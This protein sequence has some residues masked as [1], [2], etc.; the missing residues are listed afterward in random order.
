MLT[1]TT[2][3]DG[4]VEVVR[5][6]GGDINV[7]RTK[8]EMIPATEP[9]R[10]VDALTA[11]V[12]ARVVLTST[13]ERRLFLAEH[14][15]A[16]GWTVADLA[17]QP[18][19]TRA[20]P[21]WAATAIELDDPSSWISTASI[22]IA[23]IHRLTRPSVLLAALYHPEVFPL[24]R[25]PLGI[26]D[27]AR[28]A[29]STLT[30]QVRLLDMQLGVTLD[31]IVATVFNDRPDILG[32]SATF[33][34]HDLL[35]GLL[36]AVSELPEPPLVMAGGSLTARNERLL[37]RRYPWLLIARSAGE[38]TITDILSPI[39]MAIWASPKFEVS[40]T[41]VRH[42]EQAPWRSTVTT[43]RPL[44]P[45]TRRPTSSPSSICWPPRSTTEA[46]LSW[47][48]PGAAPTTARSVHEA[49]RARGRAPTLEHCHGS[50]AQWPKCLTAT[51]RSRAP[52]TW[53]T[54]N[55]SAGDPTPSPGR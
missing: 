10:L 31:D 26:S 41:P 36:D 30:G 42:T 53:S 18:H 33:G 17:G 5:R 20:W 44:W 43:R 11:A 16:A 15:G 38:P 39:G 22:S 55:S 6:V 24:P 14:R 28:A 29:R 23:G 27:L 49:T 2:F 7:C 40:A 46:W 45:T 32:V 19:R 47:S 13:L 35:V 1:P 25:F 21:S 3:H 8:I 54:K 12:P 4:I 9:N 52:C 37:L 34:Q 48:P 51:P 50:P